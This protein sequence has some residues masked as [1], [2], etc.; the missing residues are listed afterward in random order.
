LERDIK[1]LSSG[2]V[3]EL[4]GPPLALRQ[5]FDFIVV[6]LE[7]RECMSIQRLAR[8]G[9]LYTI[10]GMNWRLAFW[11]KKAC[12]DCSLLKM[13]LPK[14]RD[15]CLPSKTTHIQCLHWELISFTMSFLE[16]C[17]C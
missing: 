2:H 5:E 7:Q 15:V 6:E 4:A 14:V 3:L 17:I 8:S 9:S 11:L 1:T 10:S 16:S 12:R 13:P